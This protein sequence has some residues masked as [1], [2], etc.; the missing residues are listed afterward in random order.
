[1]RRHVGWCRKAASV[2]N[3]HANTACDSCRGRAS[4]R[5]CQACLQMSWTPLVA[6][7]CTCLLGAHNAPTCRLVLK[8]RQRRECTCQ[9]GMRLMSRSRKRQAEPGMSTDVMDTSGGCGLHLSALCA[10]CTDMLADASQTTA[11]ALDDPMWR[12]DAPGTGGRIGLWPRLS[13]HIACMP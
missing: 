13:V 1:M 4:A 8:S 11:L 6:V 5:K 2:G 3:A 10:A 9:H 7:A 12:Y